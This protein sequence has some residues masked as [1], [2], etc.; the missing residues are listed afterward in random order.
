[1]ESYIL[2]IYRREKGIPHRIIGII[3]ESGVEEKQAF[4][5]LDELW[6]I[7]NPA[8]ARQAPGEQNKESKGHKK[9]KP[10]RKA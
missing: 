7:L 10:E 6:R 3:E 8:Q 9:R 2:R 5:C 4:T 1:L